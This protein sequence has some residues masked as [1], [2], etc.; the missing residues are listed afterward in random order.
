MAINALQSA[1]SGLSALNTALDVTANNLANINTTGFKSSR[2][3]YQDLL[4]LHKLQPGVEN[5]IGDKTPA[6]VQVGLGVKVAST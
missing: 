5:A 4:Y 3:N 1:S 6:G 2:V